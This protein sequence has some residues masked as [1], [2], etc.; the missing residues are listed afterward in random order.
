MTEV[1]SST[2]LAVP[3]D[4]VWETIG[5]FGGLADWHPAVEKCELENGGKQRRIAIVGGGEIVETLEQQ[6]DDGRSYVY[7][8]VSSPLPIAN[9]TAKL[10]VEPDGDGCKIH[11]SS[12][13]D[14]QG[15]EA[16]AS[17]VVKGI[18]DAGFDNL[19]KMWG[20]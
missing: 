16:D 2:K 1:S 6:D 8:I 11:W 7:S 20:L 3:A 4:K 12:T 17:K 9:Y 5:T 18:Y 15:P 13:F 14:A 10:R 19:K